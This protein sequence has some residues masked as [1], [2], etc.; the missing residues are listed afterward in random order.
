MKQSAVAVSL[1]LLTVAGVAQAADQFIPIP[2]YRVGAYA[3]GGAKFYGGMIDYTT[4]S[5]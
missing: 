1:A 4:T 2:S 3:S 5:T